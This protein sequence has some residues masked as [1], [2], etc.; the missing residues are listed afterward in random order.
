MEVR[1]HP[2][3][4]RAREAPLVRDNVILVG[5]A[6]GLLDPLTGEG[7]FGAVW[8]GIEAAKHIESYL[9]GIVPSLDGYQVA[10]DD[11]IGADLQ[12][13]LKLHMLFHTWPPAWARFVERS[14]RAWLL[15]CAL[16]TGDARY[17]DIRRRSRLLGGGV[18]MASAVVGAAAR[19]HRDRR[20]RALS[21]T[22]LS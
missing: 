3:P 5:D 9:A 12:M 13:A 4:V 19:R 20:V 8:S 18:D 10:V 17:A 21:A 11:E 16:L 2:L 14:P 15:V 7:I 6:A 1:G 22:A